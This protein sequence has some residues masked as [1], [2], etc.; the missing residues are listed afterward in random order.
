MA[1]LTLTL[2]E[3]KTYLWF[4]SNNHLIW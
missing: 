2:A 1:C 4:I 3:T